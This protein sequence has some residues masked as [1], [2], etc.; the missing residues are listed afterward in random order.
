M[1]RTDACESIAREMHSVMA[2]QCDCIGSLE[3]SDLMPEE[4]EFYSLHS[5]LDGLSVAWPALH[6]CDGSRAVLVA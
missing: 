4:R 3:C 5:C 2:M 6:T 1:D